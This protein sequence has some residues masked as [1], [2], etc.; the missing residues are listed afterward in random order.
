MILFFCK[1]SNL[2]KKSIRSNLQ[3]LNQC[4]IAK[5]FRETLC[6]L[7]CFFLL[8]CFCL[9]AFDFLSSRQFSD[10]LHLVD[11]LFEF[12]VVNAYNSKSFDIVREDEI[13]VKRRKRRLFFSC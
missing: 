10:F 4:M 11:I 13:S 3:S 12:S 8:F 2:H 7:K 1:F 9:F 6:L 5:T